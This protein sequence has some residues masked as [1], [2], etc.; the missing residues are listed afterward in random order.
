VGVESTVLDLTGAHPTLLRPGGATLEAV[1]ALIGPVAQGG[2]SG[3]AVRS[4]GMLASHYAPALP[5]R[6]HAGDARPGEALLAFGP[7]PPGAPLAFNLSAGG[8]LTEA[9][10]RLFS[11]LRWLDAEAVRRGLTRIAVMEVP[12]TGLGRA[13]NDRLRRAAAP[14]DR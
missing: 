11:G 10:A 14:R 8:D 12:E 1:E 7:P 2:A 5:V 13:I 6:L 4:P 3:A 9:A